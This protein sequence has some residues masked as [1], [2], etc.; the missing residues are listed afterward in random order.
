MY[1]THKIAPLFLPAFTV[2]FLNFGMLQGVYGLKSHSEV[3]SVS[4]FVL[5]PKLFNVF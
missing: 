3:P 4:L 5:S 2:V 1:T